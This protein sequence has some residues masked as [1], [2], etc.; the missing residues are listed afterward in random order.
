MTSKCY[1]TWLPGFLTAIEI[2]SAALSSELDGAAV[3]GV[4]WQAVPGRFR[5]EVPEVARYLIEAG[6]RIVI[7][8]MPQSDAGDVMRFLRMTPLAALLYQRGMLALH[9]A[10][11]ATSQGCILLAGDSGTGKSTLLAYLLQRGWALLADELA[12]VDL[13]KQGYP[14]VYPT[15]SEV[16]LWRDAVEQIGLPPMDAGKRQIFN[17]TDRFCASP[18]PLRA[19]YWLRVEHPDQVEV[20]QLAGTE[21]FRALGALAYN[22]HIADVLLDRTAFFRVA[23][24]L[25]QTVPLFRL[26][27]PRGRW[28]AGELADVVARGQT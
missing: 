25:V 11:V 13:D 10:A 6:R 8:A 15:F 4:L 27:R 7:D 12:V 19:I 20:C 22:S 17:F 2:T 5:L 9:A 14:V 24:A 18:A 21:R 23:T 28:S 26:R 1:N 16:V 3:R